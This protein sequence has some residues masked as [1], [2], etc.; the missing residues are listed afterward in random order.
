M[1]R[2]QFSV[3]F[4]TFVLVPIAL[5]FVL[6][7]TGCGLKDLLNPFVDAKTQAL[8][9]VN[10]AINALGATNADWEA[11]IKDL[12]NKLPA[13][14]D[15]TIKTEIA[16]TLTRA[17]AT[18]GTEFR[19][20]VDFV[21]DR[22]REHLLRVKAVL[23]GQ[24]PPSVEPVF[25]EVVPLAIDM[26]LDPA[27]RNLLEFYGY[28]MDTVNVQVLVQNSNGTKD[29]TPRLAR[30]THYH[31]TLDLGGNPNPLTANAQKVLLKWSG[32]EI[33]S[34]S[35]IQPTTPVCQSTVSPA[36]PQQPITF[37][38]PKVHG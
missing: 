13:A 2:T 8:N 29:I 36:M 22:A 25:C 1:K 18:A 4:L 30:P 27:R 5:L 10:D 23:L 21:A 15:S 6:L 26:N 38:P 33:S 16:N 31:M 24:N 9:E 35:V 3:L 20:G 17:E 12:E 37:T 14:I 34:M 11:I 19:C 28:D 7:T 32:S